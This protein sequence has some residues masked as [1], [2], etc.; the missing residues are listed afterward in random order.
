MKNKL[1]LSSLIYYYGLVLIVCIFIF[2][3]LNGF[4]YFV[5]SRTYQFGPYYVP[6]VTEIS[7]IYPFGIGA[8]ALIN[9][10]LCYQL[11][12]Q[13]NLPSWAKILF[14]NPYSLLLLTNFTKE[15]V[16]F[17]GIFL[18]FY[19]GKKMSESRNF[20]EWLRLLIAKFSS[21]FLFLPRYVYVVLIFAS[22]YYYFFIGV[23]CFF[24]LYWSEDFLVDLARRADYG[25]VGRDFFVGLCV[26]E[27]SDPIDFTLCWFP[28][29][30]G[31][32]IHYEIFSINYLIFLSG[33]LPFLMLIPF[34]MLHKSLEFYL[35]IITSAALHWYILYQSPSFG[36]FYRYYHPVMWFVAFLAIS[37]KYTNVIKVNL[38]ISR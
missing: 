5:D 18:F 2:S 17:L 11:I 13:P 9:S 35:I 14:V 26:N 1:T 34:L 28:V 6:I 23:V 8:L 25:H 12:K 27:K 15:G 22:K 38:K 37:A 36:A 20:R 4:L 7:Y 21:I 3:A 30:L 32:P 19:F 29:F 16:I 33:Y 24:L 10:Y 31:V